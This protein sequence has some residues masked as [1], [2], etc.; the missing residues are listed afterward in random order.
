MY[1]YNPVALYSATMAALL[2][3]TLI[4]MDSLLLPI[5]FGKRVE[6]EFDDTI[7]NGYGR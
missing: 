7:G 6:G 2:F 4:C 3:L 1:Y 5:I